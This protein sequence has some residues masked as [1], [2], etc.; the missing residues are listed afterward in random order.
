MPDLE[1]K[2]L[3]H[4][5]LANTQFQGHPTAREARTRNLLVCLGR[6]RE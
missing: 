1:D 3:A 2:L 5:L 4:K 6:I